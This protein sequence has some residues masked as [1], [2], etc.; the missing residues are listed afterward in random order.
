M[1]LQDRFWPRGPVLGAGGVVPILFVDFLLANL[2][3][4]FG[5]TIWPM[6]SGGVCAYKRS[7]RAELARGEEQQQERRDTDHLLNKLAFCGQRTRKPPTTTLF[8]FPNLTLTARFH[9][10]MWIW[11]IDFI[12]NSDRL[13]DDVCNPAMD[14]FDKAREK[15]A[16]LNSAE[17]EKAASIC[18]EASNVPQNH[19]TSASFSFFARPAIPASDPPITNPVGTRHLDTNT[20]VPCVTLLFTAVPRFPSHLFMASS[21]SRSSL[22]SYAPFLQ[23]SAR[24]YRGRNL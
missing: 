3:D 17:G 2:N 11:T 18:I 15:K 5:G 1:D 23:I 22:S 10:R 4:F 9:A 24:I 8:L 16:Y 21:T 12:H 7:R 6:N 19:V 14:D 20:A 13:S